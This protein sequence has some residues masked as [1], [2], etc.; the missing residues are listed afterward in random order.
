M[1]ETEDSFAVARGLLE[2]LEERFRIGDADPAAVRATMV[3]VIGA[4]ASHGRPPP[5]GDKPQRGLGY[6]QKDRDGHLT[7]DDAMIVAS[8]PWFGG[9]MSDAI[10]DHYPEAD[11]EKVRVHARRIRTHRDEIIAVEG[12][13]HPWETSL[14][15]LGD[16]PKK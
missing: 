16:L 5:A 11:D 14:N 9:N 1:T 15:W 10:R 6:G 8:L 12:D 7:P 2:L 4:L 3:N 13:D